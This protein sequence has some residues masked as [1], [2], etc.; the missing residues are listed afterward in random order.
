MRSVGVCLVLM[1]AATLVAAQNTNDEKSGIVSVPEQIHKAPPPSP[2]ETADALEYKADVFRVEKNYTDSVDYYRAAI[3]KFPDKKA[4]S[5]LYNKLGVVF[6]EMLNFNAAEGAFVRALKLDKTNATA[7]NNLGAVYYYKHKYGKAVKVYKKALSLDDENAT[8]H[9]NLGTAYFGQKKWD[10]AT[11]EY[12]RAMQLDPGV[13][14]QHS[15]AGVSIVFSSPEDHARYVYMVAKM[16]ST[17]GNLDKSLEYLRKAIEE[18]YPY[19][20]NAIKDPAF[21]NLRK[22]PRFDELM[23][24][25]P[26]A[27][28]E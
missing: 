23:K 1:L 24:N 6:V 13:F 19:I 8:Y 28:P 20:D 5:A 7:I 9:K 27:V 15:T 21:A 3:A 12:S 26:K 4:P 17:S 25:R 10:D 18:G 22:D 16:F 14:E 2:D 11:K